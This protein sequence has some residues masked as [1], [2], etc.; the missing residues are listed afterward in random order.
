ME[1]NFELWAEG[2]IAIMEIIYKKVTETGKRIEEHTRLPM[3]RVTKPLGLWNPDQAS[4]NE[5]SSITEL[6]RKFGLFIAVDILRTP[7][8]VVSKEQFFKA[9][10]RF[11]AMG[12]EYKKG[13]SVFGPKWN[14]VRQ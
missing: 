7:R 11:E 5:Q 8:S 6:M 4:T 12:Y 2:M 9:S 3:D 10:K 14:E 1:Q 13:K